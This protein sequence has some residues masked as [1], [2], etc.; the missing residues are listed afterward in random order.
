MAS[1]AI[2]PARSAHRSARAAQPI[3]VRVSQPKPK[4]KHHRKSKGAI[5]AGSIKTLGVFA[6]AGY[7]M[8]FLDKQ[9]N[10]PTVPMLGRAGT[11]AVALHFF[12]KG[13]P[14]LREAALAAAAI[15]GYE[16]G[17]KGQVSGLARQVSGIASQV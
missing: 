2:V 12:G 5:Q 14:M 16:F 8:G 3:T 6:V 7:A 1:T 15:A 13:N 11:I 10:I 9:T 17:N 4:V